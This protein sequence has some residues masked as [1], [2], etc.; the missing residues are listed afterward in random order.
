MFVSMTTMH[1]LQ[2]MHN[3]PSVSIIIPTY[4]E[5]NYIHELLERIQ[6]SVEPLRVPYE[7]II[8][9]DDSLALELGTLLHII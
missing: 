6:R 1:Q 3:N 5:R 7:I 8:V 2:P 4:N 9:D